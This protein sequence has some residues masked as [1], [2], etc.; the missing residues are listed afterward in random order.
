M[1]FTNYDDYTCMYMFF[2]MSKQGKIHVYP[3]HVYPSV[4]Q[5]LISYDLNQES[6]KKTIEH[7]F[8]KMYFNNKVDRFYLK[9]RSYDV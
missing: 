6:I 7:L 5:F 3:K 4:T 9:M 2:N 8:H 1:F